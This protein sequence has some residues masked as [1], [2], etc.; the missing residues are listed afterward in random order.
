MTQLNETLLNSIHKFYK[1]LRLKKIT[2]DLVFHEFLILRNILKIQD[3]N[4][5]PIYPSDLSAKLNLS[6]SYVTSV[7]N[8]LESKGLVIRIIDCEDR[9]RI[10]IDVTSEG[11]NIFD[12]MVQKELQQADLLIHNLSVIKANQLIELLDQATQIL[13]KGE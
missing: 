9:R 8:S 4:K 5:T 2:S 12:N 6:R 10:K 7:L 1:T 11:Q 3:T 13:T